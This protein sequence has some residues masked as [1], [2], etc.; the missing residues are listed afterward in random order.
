[1]NSYHAVEIER[2]TT[3]MKIPFSKQRIWPKIW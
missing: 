3:G 1:M 2:G